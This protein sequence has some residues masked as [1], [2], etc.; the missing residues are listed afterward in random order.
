MNKQGLSFWYFSAFTFGGMQMIALPLLIPGYITEVTGSISESGAA[1]AMVGITGLAAPLFGSVI[2]KFRLHAHAQVFAMLAYAA[3]MLI[4]ANTSSLPLIFL[5]TALLGSASIML[6][7]VNPTFIVA[8]GLDQ[9]QQGLRLTRMNQSIFVGAIVTSL[10]LA[11]TIKMDYQ[12]S[13]YAMAI[14]ALVA[15]A[16]ILLDNFKTAKS[17]QVEAPTAESDE[18]SQTPAKFSLTFVCFLAA[19]FLAMVGSAN[20]VAQ[21]PALFESVFGIDKS[22][23]T[24]VLTITSFVSLVTLNVAG[25]WLQKAGE[26][27]VWLFGLAGYTLVGFILF[28]LAQL[29]GVAVFIPLVLHLLFMQCLSMVDMVK[30]AIV[31]KATSMNPA[32]TQGFLL[33]AIAGGYAFGTFS[34]G[35]VGEFVSLS[36]MFAYVGLTSGAA[37][38]LAII[39]LLRLKK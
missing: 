17:I 10:I 1:L 24:W 31:V 21:G 35:L 34:G 23:T 19:V 14:M 30:P 12:S 5:A 33:F 3:S 25:K 39:T 32:T 18:Q 16:I 38:I 27:S 15:L 36:S 37:L 20:Q 29:D 6:L 8:T 28:T 7:T 2:D 9:Q 13:F 26:G 22:M 11:Q 4:L